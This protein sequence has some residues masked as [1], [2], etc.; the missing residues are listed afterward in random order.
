MAYAR[1]A[2]GCA[3]IALVSWAFYGTHV[4]GEDPLWGG[5]ELISDFEPTPAERN[6]HGLTICLA[7]FAIAAHGTWHARNR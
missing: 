7:T 6:Q 5:G 3:V 4:E 1:V 2:F